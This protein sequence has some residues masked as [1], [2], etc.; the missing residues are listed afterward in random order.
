MGLVYSGGTLQRTTI[1]GS[2][3][4]LFVADMKAKLETSGWTSSAISGGWSMFSATTSQGLNFRVDIYASGGV[5]YLDAQ[6][7]AGTITSQ[8]TVGNTLTQFYTGAATTYDIICHKF[9]YFLFQTGVTFTAPG[10]LATIYYCGVPWLPEPVQPL[11][12]SGATN[13]TPIEVTTSAAHSLMTGDFVFIDGVLGNTAAN[14]Y[15]QVTV[16]STTAFTLNTSVGNGAYT[17]GGRVGTT[18]RVSRAFFAVNN[19]FT[20]G[21]VSYAPTWRGAPDG[22]GSGASG[23]GRALIVIN[24]AAY[25]GTPNDLLFYTQ[26]NTYPWRESRLAI[27]EPYV[28]GAISAGGTKQLQFQLFNAAIVN[29]TPQIAVD[30]TTSFDSHAWHCFGSATAVALFLAYT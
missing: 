3:A 21:F 26:S 29:G 20:G 23:R 15:Y 14:G 1:D 16:T 22:T 11:A 10:A 9:G 17:S 30:V 6:N 19:N 12:V 4:A 25:S 27:T 2:S 13:A 28:M 8:G 18:E 24:N 7:V 5:A